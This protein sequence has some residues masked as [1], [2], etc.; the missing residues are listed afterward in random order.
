MRNAVAQSITIFAR[1]PM[2]VGLASLARVTVAMAA[3]EVASRR[4]NEQE[5]R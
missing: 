3:D 1:V 4:H 5:S 2:V